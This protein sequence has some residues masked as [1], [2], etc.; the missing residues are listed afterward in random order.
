[1]ARMSKRERVQSRLTGKA[2]ASA[3]AYRAQL[4]NASPKETS[5]GYSRSSC[6]ADALKLNTHT[7]GISLG[8]RET[9]FLKPGSEA[10]K[11]NKIRY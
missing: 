9:H 7:Q 10:L 1:M 6:S 4:V 11:L 3:I 8:T 5:R 2:V